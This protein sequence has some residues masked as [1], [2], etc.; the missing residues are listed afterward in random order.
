MKLGEA[1][2]VRARQAQRMN[3][4]LGRIKA[5]AQVQEGDTAPEDVNMLIEA[6]LAV[7]EDHSLLVAKIART[8]NSLM[9]GAARSLLD[10]IQEREEMI[11]RRNMYGMIAKAAS[12][13][14]YAYRYSR[15]EIKTQPTVDIATMRQY[16]DNANRRVGELDIQIQQINWNTDLV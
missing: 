2:T 8:N 6:Y 11:R 7:S 3:D 4:I 10:L 1:L 5:S 12:P 16:E 13:G 9:V 14:D 15:T